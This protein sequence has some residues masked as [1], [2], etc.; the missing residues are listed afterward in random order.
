MVTPANVEAL[1]RH[2]PL[3]A[4]LDAPLLEALSRHCRKRAFPAHEALFHEGDPGHTL[5]VVLSGLVSVQRTTSQGRQLPVARRGPGEHIGEMS[6]LDGSPRMADATTLMP[7]EVLM[8][9]RDAF[10]ECLDNS[11]A[12]ARRLLACLANRLREATDALDARESQDATARL[13]ACLV[14]LTAR[15]GECQPDG[16]VRLTQRV[17]HQDLADQTGLAR[18]SV[19]RA[20]SLLKVQGVIATREGR[21]V[22]RKPDYLAKRAGA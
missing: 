4:D 1:L 18:E 11:P 16:S 12:L 2:V 6:L 21:L 5:Y 15:E 14:D 8:L 9:D 17:T 19:S 7:T 10:L 22:V 3:F 20:L 13:C